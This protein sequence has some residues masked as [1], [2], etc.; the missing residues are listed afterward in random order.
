MH[1][2]PRRQ[3][4]T[5]IELLVVIA[6][7]AVLIA[8]LLPAVQK[9]REAA[10]RTQC[11]NNLKQIGIAIAG[12]CDNHAGRFPLTTHTEG[13]KFDKTW[14]YTLGPYLENV[15]KIRICPMD[16]LREARLENKGT[17]YVL[18]EY[19]STPASPSD[20]EADQ[21]LRITDMPATHRMITVFTVSDGRAP[22]SFS[23]H[24][25]SRNWF[26]PGLTAAQRWE[27]IIQ[28]IQVDRFN[29]TLGADPKENHTAGYANYL[30]AD[31]HVELIPAAQIRMYSDLNYNFARPNPPTLPPN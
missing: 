11:K 15:D 30:F 6:I 18:N 12:Y 31:G 10:L 7:I 23:D 24:T 3:G 25:H 9:A 20:P 1:R 21:A 16:P 17:S 28:D 4:F 22:S 29:G 27:R 2:Q 26:K 14:I 19:I 8:L 13:F 5:L